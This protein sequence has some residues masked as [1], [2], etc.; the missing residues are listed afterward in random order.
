[1]ERLKAF[2][3][4]NPNV[5]VEVRVKALD[6]PGGLLD[7]LTTASAA[8]PLAMPDLV[9]LPRSLM[10]TAA[11]KGLLHPFDQLTDILSA[12]DWYPY[13]HQLAR[14]QN[15]TFGIPFAGDAL[16]LAYHPTLLPIPPVSW[17]EAVADQAALAFPASDPQALF[18]LAMYQAAGG[19]VEDALGRPT[20]DAGILT[21]VLVFYQHAALSQTMPFWLTQFETDDQVWGSF[22]RDQSAAVVTWASRYL[23]EAGSLAEKAEAATLPTPTRTPFTLAT[24][25]VWALS[26]PDSSRWALSTRLAEY[27]VEAQFLAQWTAANGLLP[28][29]VAALEAWPNE[30]Q[31]ALIAKL[32]TSAQLY[33]SANALSSLGPALK[34]AVIDVLKQQVLPVDAAQAALDYL[35]N[36]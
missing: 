12:E 25:W 23:S 2:T 8:A 29:R 19:E 18:T 16:L 13:T 32:S 9:A 14:L 34:L 5:Q 35:K 27:L 30:S 10:E 26:S 21:Q 6:G 17:E 36:P 20:L 22:Q 7:T 1:M 3:Q 11:L 33:P 28:P 15:S 31:R 4:E 24:G